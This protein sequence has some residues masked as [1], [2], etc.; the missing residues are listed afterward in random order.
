MDFLFQYSWAKIE[1]KTSLKVLSNQVL[2]KR[3][4][5]ERFKFLR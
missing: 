4:F 1:I 5:A 2:I 3:Y